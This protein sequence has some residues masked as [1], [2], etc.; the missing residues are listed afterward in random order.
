M[1]STFDSDPT[2]LQQRSAASHDRGSAATV[3]PVRL[4]GDSS[5]LFRSFW[6]GGFESACHINRSGVRIDMVSATQHDE[7]VDEDYLRLVDWGI[8]TVR[9]GARWHLIETPRG[10]DYSSLRPTIEAA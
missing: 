3:T 9:E 5:S 6:I 7:L 1:V 10:F 8:H 2:S 4:R